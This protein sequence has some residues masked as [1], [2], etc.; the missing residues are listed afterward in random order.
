MIT[1]LQH[2]WQ[3]MR[4]S[5]WFIPTLIVLDA[6]ALA[7]LLITVDA[8]VDLQ[9]LERWPLIFG[10]GA[11]GARGLLT[12]VASS[13]ITVAGVVFSITIVA[14][15]L[16]SSQYTSRVLRNFMRDRINQIVLGVFVG[17]F[18]YCLVVL[19]VIRGGDEGA[20][21]PSLAVLVGL[22]LAFVGIGYLIFFIHYIS[23]SIQASSIIG[24]AAQETLAAVD[25]LF[26]QELG[27]D[28]EEDADGYLV[29]SFAG[30]AWSAVPACKTGYIESIDADALL[31]LARKYQT[32]VRME[33]GIGEFVVEGTPLISVAKR[34]SLDD[35][36]TNELNG[37]YV[38]GRQ[39][40]VEQDAAFGIRQLVDIAMKALSPGINDTTTAVICVD[41]LTAIL[42]RLA[43][44]RITTSHWMD[45][46]GELRVMA[47]GPSFESL[48]SEAFDQI[49]QNAGGN[50][51]ILSRM[52]G[53]LQTIAGL[54][55]SS[56]RRWLLR[57]KVAEIA[58]A[59]ERTIESP[60]DRVRFESR[61]AR[62]REALEPGLVSATHEKLT[63]A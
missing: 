27:E 18:A 11:S 4:S 41:Y 52:L 42:A 62:V 9:V 17:I 44:R 10:A 36:T 13:M 54:T 35:A 30:Q 2:E 6:V 23:K 22:I 28:A 50:V 63:T 57:Q 33:H 56:S 49:R 20:F 15:S 14:L 12:T 58:E 24:I 60:H 31:D 43:T 61:L 3:E 21:V 29:R 1:K 46:Q 47:R 59:A 5:F 45:D 48:L 53:A 38:I 19:R 55:A 34:G 25:H 8:T 32:I 39:R 40:V 37:A 16:T 51:A 7:T 26:P